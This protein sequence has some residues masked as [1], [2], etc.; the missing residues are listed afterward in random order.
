MWQLQQR[1]RLLRV[2]WAA[3]ALERRISLRS[4][5]ALTEGRGLG[6]GARRGVVA[7]V[8]LRLVVT[9]GGIGGSV[10]GEE[11][12]AMWGMG[13]VPIVVGAVLVGV[14]SVGA[15][16]VGIGRVCVGSMR[17]YMRLWNSCVSSGVI[18]W[19]VGKRKEKVG[20]R[21]TSSGCGGYPWISEYVSRNWRRGA[22]FSSGMRIA[23][24]KSS[25]RVCW[26]AWTSAS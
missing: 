21:G 14:G 23:S 25:R 17:E 22:L 24:W 2:V 13:V 26:V 5:L 10:G 3:R 8:T 16:G 20:Q 18:L 19:S 6:E 11:G 15:G 4:G 1:R 7:G 12:A 9:G